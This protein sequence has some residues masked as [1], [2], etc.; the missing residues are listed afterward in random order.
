MHVPESGRRPTSGPL[1]HG[2]DM[3]PALVRPKQKGFSLLEIMVVLAILGILVAIA[4]PNF[5]NAREKA[6]ATQC[7]TIRRQINLDEQ[8]YYLA[9]NKANLVI[10][11]QHRCPSG[12]TLVW[13]I[14]DPEKQHYPR[15]D[16]SLH[17][18]E[19]PQDIVPEKKGLDIIAGLV[20]GFSIDEGAGC[21]DCQNS[22]YSGRMGIYEIMLMTPALKSLIKPGLS[23]VELKTAAGRECYR[24]MA[25][26]GIEKALAG[27]TTIEEVFRV[28]PPD[29]QAAPPARRRPDKAP[30]ANAIK[31]S[32]VEAEVKSQAEPS[33][34][35]AVSAFTE[36]APAD[37]KNRVL[38]VLVVDDSE[39]DR[40]VVCDALEDEGYGT[41]TAED[42]LE[43]LEAIKIQIPDL[44]VV[45]YD[46]PYGRRKADKG[47][48]GQ[49]G[50]PVHSHFNAHL[51]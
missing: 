45:D 21:E 10:A 25:A 4:L 42:G 2:M 13:L 44:M 14:S 8:D 46:A 47:V 19:I 3:A 5:I 38:N 20:A 51:S 28:A 23:P 35:Q 49:A 43:A 32:A 22:G 7:M 40:M 26:D 6:Q 17:F 27:L 1:T 37:Q 30:I 15:V 33:S 18:S 31:T 29:M 12:G 48:E 9:N 50:H 24:T 39:I 41:T 34:S 11:S 16:C 36:T